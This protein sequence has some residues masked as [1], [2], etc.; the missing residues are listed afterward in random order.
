[1]QSS[2]CVTKNKTNEE[3]GRE[4]NMSDEKNPGSEQKDVGTS[5]G[6]F[7]LGDNRQRSRKMHEP[8]SREP[9]I[10]LS[11]NSLNEAIRKELQYF[12]LAVATPFRVV[13]R[14]FRENSAPWAQGL[15]QLT[16]AIEGMARIP[17]KVLQAVVGEDFSKQNDQ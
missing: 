4:P 6:Q 8:H 2:W 16:W 9:E 17:V 13:R 11:V 3:K 15:E 7:D 1:M 10:S 12:D 14:S 5:G